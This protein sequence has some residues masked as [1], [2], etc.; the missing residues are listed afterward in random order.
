MNVGGGRGGGG[1]ELVKSVLGALPTYLLTAV[2]PPRHGQAQETVF[3]GW[4]PRAARGQ[5]QSQLA[6]GQPAVAVRRTRH[7]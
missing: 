7:R 4:E 2:K 6:T 3:V 1:E 5:M